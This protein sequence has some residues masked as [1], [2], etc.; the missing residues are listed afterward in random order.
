MPGNDDADHEPAAAAAG[1]GQPPPAGDDSADEQ[2][3]D[4][5]ADPL[6]RLLMRMDRRAARAERAAADQQALTAELRRAL[7]TQAE[8]LA[9]LRA[10]LPRPPAAPPA[11][12]DDD[13]A[14]P[15]PDPAGA[16]T[17]TP[18]PPP[19]RPLGL[20]VP[21]SAASQSSVARAAPETRA[22]TRLVAED[23]DVRS[24]ISNVSRHD[25]TSKN[26]QNF[27]RAAEKQAPFCGDDSNDV[28]EWLTS[29]EELADTHGVD[30]DEVLQGLKTLLSKS[31]RRFFREHLAQVTASGGP[32]DW[33]TARSWFLRKFNPESRVLRK[34]TEYHRCTQG[35]RS[36]NDYLNELLEL[37]AY[38]ST[39]PGT[40]LEQRV[41]FL[42][43]L[44]QDLG[45]EVRKHLA[46]SPGAD[47]D[48]TVELARNLAD[49]M[50]KDFSR[51]STALRAIDAAQVR[52]YN[53]NEMGH[54]STDCPSEATQAS[55]DAA[56]I[57]AAKKAKND[58]RR[59][60]GR[61]AKAAAIAAEKDKDKDKDTDKTSNETQTKIVDKD[62]PPGRPKK[63]CPV[64]AST[65]VS[66]VGT[67]PSRA[68]PVLE[69][70][71]CIDGKPIRLGLDTLAGL[72]C[73][74]KADLTPDERKRCVPT[75][76]RLH[77]AGGDALR[78][79]SEIELAIEVA[80]DVLLVKFNVIDTGKHNLGFLF[81]MDALERFEFVIDAARRAVTFCPVPMPHEDLLR[82]RAD[83][84]QQLLSAGVKAVRVADVPRV[85][86]D[87]SPP[88]DVSRR[89]T[90]IRSVIAKQETVVPA[91]SKL[92]V[93]GIFT[94]HDGDF[95]P[96]GNSRDFVYFPPDDDSK[97]ATNIFGLGLWPGLSRAQRSPD[98][99]SKLLE[100]PV[101]VVNAT[102][103]PRVLKANTLLGTVDANAT[104]VGLDTYLL[105]DTYVHWLESEFNFDK[106]RFNEVFSLDADF[107]STSWCRRKVWVNPPWEL[108]D[109]AVE[110]LVDDA[111]AE[112]VVLGLNSNKQWAQTLRNM[113]CAER[114]V[115][116]TGGTGFFTQ[117]LSDGSFRDLPF[118][119]WDLVAF[120]GTRDLVLAY[121]ASNVTPPT[122]SGV[123]ATSSTTASSPVSDEYL[124]V[125]YAPT[126]TESQLTEAKALVAEFAD[127]FDDSAIA[128]RIVG[129]E[130][131]I[132]TGDHA[133]LSVQPFQVSPAKRAKIDA[134]ID[135]ML[136]LG[137][138]EPSTS[139]W[140]SRFFLVPQPGREDREVVD[141]RPLN[142]VTKRDVYPLPRI[143]DT[144]ML[145]HGLKF[146]STFDG[147]KGFWQIKNTERAKLR[148]AFICHR[149]LYQFRVMSFGLKNAPSIFQRMMDTTFA[150]LKWVICLLY[151]D[152]V[153]VWSDCWVVHI[154]RT[155]KVFER[156]RE[157]NLCLKAA[158]SF[159]G[160]TELTCLGHTVNA[161][162]R[163]PDAKKTIA[164]SALK[165]PSNVNELATFLGM[166]N[167]YSEYV[168]NY[169]AVTY[170]LNELRKKD[171]VWEWT[172]QHR[173]AVA[174]LKAALTSDA[175]LVH[176]DY[177]KPFIVMPDASIF[178]VG[179]VL[180]Q[181]DSEGRERPIS[182][183]SK[184][185][186]A[187]EQ[188]Y[189]VYELEAL[190]VVYSVRKF[191]HYIEGTTFRL[192]TDHNALLWLFRQPILRG[193]LA[194]WALDLQ[195]FDFT[196][197]HRAGRAHIVPDAV[198]RLPRVDD[199]DTN[200]EQDV[201]VDDVCDKAFTVSNFASAPLRATLSSLVAKAQ[202]LTTAEYE[203][204]P[205]YN[206]RFAECPVS[207]LVSLAVAQQL[208][209]AKFDIK[210]GFHH[211]DLDFLETPSARVAPLGSSGRITPF[212]PQSDPDDARLSSHFS[213]AKS[214]TGHSKDLSVS[215]RD[216]NSVSTP[217]LTLTVPDDD[218]LRTL[219]ATRQD[220]S[221]TLK[222]LQN[223]KVGLKGLMKLDKYVDELEIRF[224]LMVH[225]DKS[226]PEYVGKV[227]PRSAWPRVLHY[228]HSG[229]T[230]NHLGAAKILDRMKR[231]VW[232]PSMEADVERVC[233]ACVLC[234]NK[235]ATAPP[236]VRPLQPVVSEYPNHIVA[237]DLF[238]PFLP[239][240]QGNCYVSVATDLFT[241][242]VNLRPTPSAKAMD[243]AKTLRQW[244]TRNG[245][246]TKFLTDRGPNYTSEVLR[247]LA[248]LFDITKVFTTSGH[249]EA[250]G[251]AERLVKTVTG[252][253][254]ASWESD[255]DWDENVD[256]YEYALN[257]SYHPAVDNV[258]YVLWFARMPTPLVELEDRADRRAGA[259]RWAD[260]RAY[261]K[262]TLDEALKAVA[263]VREVQQKVKADMKRRHDDRIKLVDLRVGDL[264]YRY[265]EA[266]PVRSTNLP[267][268]RLHRHWHG[269]FF[270]TKL[271]GENAEL[272]DA[273]TGD[274]KLYHRNLCVRYVYPLAG[275]QLLGER[276][277]AYLES[278]TGRRTQRGGNLQFNCLWRS[279]DAT[280][281]EWLD[282]ADVPTNLI[283]E[284][285]KR[286]AGAALAVGV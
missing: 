33:P 139:P 86:D 186:N 278:V 173:A 179:G 27:L 170:P 16:P 15:R 99:P 175:V 159:V 32:W 281:L 97:A 219:Q 29:V 110:K 265:N 92:M 101:H 211:V 42:A 158:K 46:A 214:P 143:D 269:P 213:P 166:T 9:A 284:F 230:V 206:P 236:H 59:R 79:D 217:V 28:N 103:T 74:G 95:L 276:R 259:W 104:V 128:G 218:E 35:R 50:P 75:S 157:R 212:R 165:D 6:M 26:Y 138:I 70:A 88:P 80:G 123:R 4:Q 176:P 167:F 78:S 63:T 150:G 55:K 210:D 182:L 181:L 5:Q 178:A 198:S 285:E 112:F 268:R 113:G 200:D 145:L 177:S 244:I 142:G 193:K 146:V 184:K 109:A 122:S 37:R 190:G 263:R 36:V 241:K 22:S 134:K 43:G 94:A 197:E 61:E 69:I 152:D 65:R 163:R 237:M 273:K 207:V 116:K 249:K 272:L 58:E 235:R 2:P 199:H 234:L 160:F 10:L 253:M 82:F 172:D 168:P 196:I 8:E 189:A 81:G 23:D 131:D 91:F 216:A 19:P 133:P 226:N 221:G 231:C 185:L 266:T 120:Y 13:V 90:T 11:H 202:T 258:P 77:H 192:V 49:V 108:L 162:G 180:A 18:G 279:K 169:A 171:A 125:K 261:A 130:C 262:C 209:L 187:A 111:P 93:T 147:S 51:D 245:P 271:V 161:A 242:Y 126:L 215:D 260:R 102:R 66:E 60:R 141:Y 188:K 233:R 87:G 275:L 68:A 225:V 67:T 48:T 71:A 124:N 73:V 132:D 12:P 135:K 239:T 277:N 115:P 254:V 100:L 7:D 151:L 40:D 232:W 41:R 137:I 227:I 1:A 228:F 251:Q 252:M 56:A 238:G 191:R 98:S 30:T 174:N 183:R 57:R 114:I 164:I 118:P 208:D 194:R 24:V 31:A 52:C 243:S 72:S 39:G 201:P 62:R 17:P 240:R 136:Q 224:G 45:Y 155:R 247:E 223:D 250:N 264:C 222:Y 76:E 246:M 44:R 20:A 148:S 283:E 84:E 153:I 129:V 14:T 53:C 38:T 274:K 106:S 127:I 220:T 89:V 280:E 248:R 121:K 54:F 255:T 257:T 47:F 64:F 3:D 117:L 85:D 270:V 229:P 195:Q 256:L 205:G 96:D 107:E 156:C 203:A 34:V 144:L 204:Y 21:G 83:K 154:D 105:K 149:G 140:A 267:A 119:A 286:T 25:P 282:E